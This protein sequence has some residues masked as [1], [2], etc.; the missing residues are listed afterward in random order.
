MTKNEKGEVFDLVDYFLEFEYDLF[1]RAPHD[2]V[3]DAGAL[4]WEPD[5]EISYPSPAST[6]SSRLPRKSGESSWMSAG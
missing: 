1:P 5:M 4:I 2:D 6:R 3:L